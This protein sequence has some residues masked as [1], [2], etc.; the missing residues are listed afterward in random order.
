MAITE[1]YQNFKKNATTKLITKFAPDIK[2]ACTISDTF[3]INS[4]PPHGKGKI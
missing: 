1:N 4:P 2:I 3:L